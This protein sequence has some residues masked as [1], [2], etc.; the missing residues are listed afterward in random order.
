MWLPLLC[1]KSGAIAL[2]LPGL[3]TGW[4]V[5]AMFN[6]G[7][8]SV[9]KD[10]PIHF[11]WFFHVKPILRWI[12]EMPKFQAPFLGQSLLLSITVLNDIK[13]IAVIIMIYVNYMIL[14]YKNFHIIICT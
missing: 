4:L 13:H 10:I 12:L 6:K 8:D 5:F 11:S 7:T 14:W 1:E 9:I 2:V 3:M